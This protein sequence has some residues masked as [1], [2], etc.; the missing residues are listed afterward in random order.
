MSATGRRGRSRR[1][2]DALLADKR[3][4]VTIYSAFFVLFALAGG[5]VAIDF[6]RMALLKSEMQNRADAGA[7][8]GATQ[9][10]GRLDAR[11]RAQSLAVQAMAQTSAIPAN[12]A[13]L[14]VEAVNFYSAVEPDFVAAIDDADAAFI[15]VVMTPKTV[16]LFFQPFM[17]MLEKSDDPTARAVAASALAGPDP[18]ICHAPPLMMC[19]LDESDPTLDLTLP[20]HAGKQV[21]LKEPLAGG[22]SMAPGNFGLLALP[23]GSVGANDIQAALAAVTPADCYTLDVSTA[24]GAKTN[25]VIS[26]VNA[27]FDLPGGLPDPAPN[28]INYPR[29][30]SLVA[31]PAR[32]LGQG[33]W[34][35]EGY[36]LA[37]H[38]TSLPA[39][40]QGASRYQTYLYE[41]GEAYA[42]NGM[43]TIYPVTGSLPEGFALIEPP[44]P[45]L[46]VAADPANAD[47]PNFDGVPS[48]AVAS[49]GQA[50]RLVQVPLLQ[51]IAEG[52]SGHG[53][54]PTGGKYVEIFITETASAAPEAT[55]YGEVVRAITPSTNPDFH[56]NVRLIR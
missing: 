56:A 38:G 19:D 51:C 24:T 55:I 28:V 21:R 25:K 47:D 45:N 4:G 16:D 26:G 50:R 46:P 32:K 34:D 3:G 37:K 43:R 17:N 1:E 42:R 27:R 41:L 18:F 52:V 54:Y 40:L 39:D 7:L 5:A 2:L 13:T 35:R 6:G 11:S 20:E 8:A 29:D 30:A 36:W 48:T 49:N 22:G 9:L 14:G 31:D 33:D 23:D 15:E 44:G 53:T 10:D 12:G